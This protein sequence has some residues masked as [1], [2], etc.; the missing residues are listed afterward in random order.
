LER[1]DLDRMADR[2]HDLAAPGQRR[3][4]VVGVDYGRL[5]T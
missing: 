1:A 2:I 5:A 3:V 4:E